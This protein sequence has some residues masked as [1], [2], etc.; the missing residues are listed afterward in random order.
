MEACVEAAFRGFIKEIG[1]PPAPMLA[2]YRALIANGQVHV[3]VADGAV[4]GVIVC[5]AKPDHLFVDVVAVRPE[6][7][8]Q[9]VGRRL[10]A[11]A[12]AE[13]RRLGLGEVQLYTH[14]VMTGALALYPALGYYETARR[15]E[16]GYAR[17][18]FCQR[19]PPER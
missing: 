8:R 2:D 1:K 4:L 18:Y 16:D 15:V 5:T 17:V 3:L 13:A 14:E 7:Q 11:F 12:T 9:G 19:V 10:M 6:R